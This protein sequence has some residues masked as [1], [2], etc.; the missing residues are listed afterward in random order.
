MSNARA[1]VRRSPG[2]STVGFGPYSEAMIVTNRGANPTST[3]R[4]WGFYKRVREQFGEWNHVILT[5][6]DDLIALDPAIRRRTSWFAS[7]MTTA[8]GL[9]WLASTSATT[10]APNR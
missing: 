1:A 7:S 10:E 2:P 9:R 3:F 4:A 8:A 5:F 6:P